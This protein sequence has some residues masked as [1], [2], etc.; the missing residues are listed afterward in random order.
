M[1]H[2]IW[3]LLAV[4]GSASHHLNATAGPVFRCVDAAGAIAFQDRPCANGQHQ[5]EVTIEPAPVPSRSPEYA[6]EEGRPHAGNRASRRTHARARAV[7]FECHAS[8]GRVFYRLGACPH[9][10]KAAD[11]SR[12]PVHVSAQRVDR[13]RAC[14]QMRRAGAIGRAGHEFDEKISTYDKNLGRD[15]CA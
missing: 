8:D 3:I 10:V 15:P 2:R 13:D 14:R 12:T 6:V 11:G 4:F 5:S 1:R 9:A 7:A